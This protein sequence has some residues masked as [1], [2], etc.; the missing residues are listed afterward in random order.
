M[1]FNF[2]FVRENSGYINIEANGTVCKPLLNFSDWKII[3]SSTDE[4][5]FTNLKFMGKVILSN[6]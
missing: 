6:N 1:K 2:Y 4:N 5:N 3:F